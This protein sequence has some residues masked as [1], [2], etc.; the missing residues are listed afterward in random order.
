MVRVFEGQNIALRDINASVGGG[1]L[2]VGTR[3][4][5]RHRN[6]RDKA[7]AGD[8][9]QGVAGAASCGLVVVATITPDKLVRLWSTRGV[10]LGNLDQ[11]SS[12][13]SSAA[14]HVL[15]QAKPLL[16]GLRM[17]S[18]RQLFCFFISRVNRY[19]IYCIVD[20]LVMILVQAK[21]KP[22]E[23]NASPRLVKGP[24]RM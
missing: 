11:V 3:E 12:R 8:R 5:S 9:N 23:S 15:E 17:E 13:R 21:R 2:R 18:L 19:S 10:A 16:L 22:N 20:V 4:T 1:D 24:R 14:R 6:T 7:G